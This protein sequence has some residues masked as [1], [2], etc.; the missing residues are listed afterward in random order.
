M[1]H[2]RRNF[3]K[4]VA[5][6]AVFPAAS[7][8]A[9]QNLE[10]DASRSDDDQTT[11]VNDKDRV[12]IVRFVW[13]A[14]HVPSC[15]DAKVTYFKEDGGQGKG[16]Y[17]GGSKKGKKKPTII[18]ENYISASGGPPIDLYLQA[19]NGNY[20]RFFKPP[21][22]VKGNNKYRKIAAGKK[23]PLLLEDKIGCANSS[24]PCAFVLPA[25]RVCSHVHPR[26]EH[27]EIIIEC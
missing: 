26:L 10:T 6:A 27:T 20:S 11:V 13:V 5:A 7:L 22:P 2:D 25:V 19:W 14:E 18:I 9:P 17:G 16:P 4:A 1:N 12:A 24:T 21:L 23:M 8:A 3:A 15:V